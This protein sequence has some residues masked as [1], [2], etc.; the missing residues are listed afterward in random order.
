MA[1]YYVVLLT[2]AA[3]LASIDAASAVTDAKELTIP[4]AAVLPS[5]Q[6]SVK[7]FLRTNMEGAER[8]ATADSEER[9]VANDLTHAIGRFDGMAKTGLEQYYTFSISK[10]LSKLRKKITNKLTGK[11]QTP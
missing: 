5:H 1:L 7:R 9:G 8:D 11:N 3:L 2:V 4:E 6:D 10:W